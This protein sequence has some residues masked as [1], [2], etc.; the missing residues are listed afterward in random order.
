MINF[1]TV[2]K[3]TDLIRKQRHPCSARTA[4]ELASEYLR[5]V[6]DA[7]P[8]WFLMENAGVTD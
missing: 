5:V 8:D 6:C 4:W 2:S 3:L 7:A 1:L